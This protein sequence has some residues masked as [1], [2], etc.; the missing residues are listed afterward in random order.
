VIR[1]R[2]GI[3]LRKTALFFALSFPP[4]A[5][6]WCGD[7]ETGAGRHL[8]L[9]DFIDS[10]S[11][12]PE[13]SAQDGGCHCCPFANVAPLRDSPIGDPFHS[14]L[15][16]AIPRPESLTQDGDALVESVIRNVEGLWPKLCYRA[17]PISPDFLNRF[18]GFALDLG[19]CPELDDFPGRVSAFRP[20]AALS[21]TPAVLRGALV[22]AVQVRGNCDILTSDLMASIREL[23]V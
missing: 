2:S 4:I 6:F 3:C 5:S 15:M 13:S 18:T 16:A 8:P 1:P 17:P 12:F 14:V 20:R 10:L 21:P 19:A 23:A 9:A 7:L 11:V 22:E